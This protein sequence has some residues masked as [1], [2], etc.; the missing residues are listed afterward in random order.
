MI[1]AN[2][3]GAIQVVCKPNMGRGESAKCIHWLTGGKGEELG[4]SLHAGLS[5]TQI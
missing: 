2:K 1:G 5:G 3:L 4:Q